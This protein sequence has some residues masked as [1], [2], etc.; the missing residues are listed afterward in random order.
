[1]AGGDSSGR[2][3]RWYQIVLTPQESAAVAAAGQITLEFD[4]AVDA[5]RRVALC[6]LDLF[7]QAADVVAGRAKQQQQEQD[8]Q[9]SVEICACLLVP[10]QDHRVNCCLCTCAARS[11]VRCCAQ[12]NK[13]YTGFELLASACAMH[14]CSANHNNTSSYACCAGVAAH[15]CRSCLWTPAALQQQ[16]LCPQSSHPQQQLCKSRRLMLLRAVHQVSCC[17]RPSCRWVQQQ[18]APCLGYQQQQQ[19]LRMQALASAAAATAAQLSARVVNFSRMPWQWPASCCALM[20]Q[21]QHPGAPAG[22]VKQQHMHSSQLQWAAA[23]H[24]QTQLLILWM[25]LLVA[26]VTAAGP[27]LLH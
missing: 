6:H 3:Q 1:L 21:Q 4:P 14:Q 18:Q 8:E 27:P 10:M 2:S 20:L 9:V 15:I 19:E 13:A 5:E 16:Q 23:L 26:A 22:S 12:L 17:S 7:G 24:M 25:L 11:T